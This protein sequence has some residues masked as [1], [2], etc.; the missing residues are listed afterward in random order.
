MNARYGNLGQQTPRGHGCQGCPIHSARVKVEEK[1]KEP[2]QF[3]SACAARV[4]TVCCVKGGVFR[5]GEE[6]QDQQPWP[7]SHSGLVSSLLLPGSRCPHSSC[8]ISLN[9]SFP[10][11][12]MGVV[13]YPRGLVGGLNKQI[14]LKPPL[15]GPKSDSFRA[16]GC[17]H[18]ITVVIKAS[19]AW[20]G[21]HRQCRLLLSPPSH[22]GEVS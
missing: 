14:H 19:R 11:W 16:L 4:P 13:T 5:V 15:T 17:C 21:R 3:G 1:W 2:T 22:P 7:G 10:I 6:G 9:L 20:L 18:C 8:A 12:K